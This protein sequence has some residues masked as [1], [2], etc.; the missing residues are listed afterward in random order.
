M[1][2]VVSFQGAETMGCKFLP[3]KINTALKFLSYTNAEIVWDF[4]VQNVCKANIKIT[5]VYCAKVTV[6]WVTLLQ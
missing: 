3:K 1:P 4:S 6:F 5:A 2:S